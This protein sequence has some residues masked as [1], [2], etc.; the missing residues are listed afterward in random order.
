LEVTSGLDDM[1]KRNP[2]FYRQHKDLA[3]LSGRDCKNY[4]ILAGEILSGG[5][6]HEVVEAWQALFWFGVRELVYFVVEV[7]RQSTSVIRE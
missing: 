7:A 6:R 5:R 1:T 2:R 4:G 3:I